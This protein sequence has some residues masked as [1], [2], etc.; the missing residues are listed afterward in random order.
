[1]WHV[2]VLVGKYERREHLEDLS[3]VGL[4]VLEWDVMKGNGS[5]SVVFI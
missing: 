5:T 4:T 3:I 2:W 1:M